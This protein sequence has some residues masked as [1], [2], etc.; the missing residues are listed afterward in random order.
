MVSLPP[1]WIVNL[2]RSPDRRQ[3]MT[4]QMAALGLP[5]EFVPGVDGGDLSPNELAK[6]S[7][8]RSLRTISR[9]LNL[10]EI[11]CAFAHIRLYE[12]MVQEGREEVLILEDDVQLTGDLLELLRLRRQ[13]GI[14]WDV[15]NFAGSLRGGYVPAGGTLPGSYRLF[16]IKGTAIRTACYLITL[17][18]AKTALK[19]IFPIRAPADDAIYRYDVCRLAAYCVLPA[20]VVISGD[21]ST[22]WLPGE[23]PEYLPDVPPR[24]AY[25]AVETLFDRLRTAA[26]WIMIR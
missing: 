1:I 22:I 24:G 23:T 25:A 16:R 4:D 20:P 13:F 26:K 10:R 8:S 11:G 18:A 5:Y 14:D 2:P 15:V 3:K 21:P 17:R 9:G 7:R 19:R 6:Y 12:R